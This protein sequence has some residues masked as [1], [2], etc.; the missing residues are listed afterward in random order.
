MSH[1]QGL[2][3]R[4]ARCDED[5]KMCPDAGLCSK[6]CDPGGNITA[7]HP[8]ASQGIDLHSSMEALSTVRT[9]SLTG[10]EIVFFYLKD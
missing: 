5:T 9:T 6:R 2:G 7:F 8:A 4:R 3:L 1:E 10:Q